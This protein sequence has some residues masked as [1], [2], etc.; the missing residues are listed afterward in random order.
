MEVQGA[1]TDV[2]VLSEDIVRVSNQYR[3]VHLTCVAVSYLLGKMKMES[4]S[5]K[6][7]LIKGLLA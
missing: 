4:T 6:D 1:L 7:G 5:L 3:N 2:A